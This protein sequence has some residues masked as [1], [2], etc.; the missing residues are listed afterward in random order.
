MT[1]LMEEKEM[2]Y[3]VEKI[4]M[5][6]LME[7]KEMTLYLEVQVTTLLM[8]GLEMIQQITQLQLYPLMLTSN[9]ARLAAKEKT[10]FC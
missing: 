8:A 9:L 2:I 1:S 4:T 7:G 6:L 3:L 5:I 10:L